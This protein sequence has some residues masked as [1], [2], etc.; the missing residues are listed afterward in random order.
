MYYP[1][2]FISGEEQVQCSVMRTCI[3][4][5]K[6]CLKTR[7]INSFPREW[8]IIGW[9]I[10]QLLCYYAEL[11]SQLL[12]NFYFAQ[13]MSFILVPSKSGQAS[14]P[15]Q[16]IELGSF[17]WGHSTLTLK[18]GLSRLNT[19][20]RKYWGVSMYM[21]AVSFSP[22]CNCPAVAS[23]AHTQILHTP[24]K[25]L[26]YERITSKKFEIRSSEKLGN[27]LRTSKPYWLKF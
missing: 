10:F 26:H 21:E 12:C 25:L 4:H 17:N 24:Y 2:P 15:V 23:I 5:F 13:P 18:V 20:V 6:N 19:S 3:C 9:P 16:K 1:S 22:A 8:N 7:M 14:L 27:N 11:R